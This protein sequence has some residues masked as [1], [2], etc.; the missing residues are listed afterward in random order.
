MAHHC[1]VEITYYGVVGGTLAVLTFDGDFET[2]EVESHLFSTGDTRNWATSSCV[3][4]K[5]RSRK[6]RVRRYVGT[7]S[8]HRGTHLGSHDKARGLQN[9]RGIGVS[10][11]VCVDAEPVFLV[12]QLAF[13]SFV[14]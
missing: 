13:G 9:R 10:S 14:C 2:E 3:D 4:R 8:K 12:A 11:S 6:S 5:S 1:A 7:L